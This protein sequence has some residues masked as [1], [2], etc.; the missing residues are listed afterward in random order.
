MLAAPRSS[1]PLKTSQ[2]AKSLTFFCRSLSDDSTARVTAETPT[3]SSEI[4][5]AFKDSRKITVPACPPFLAS[6]TYPISGSS[7]WHDA[8]LSKT[9]REP[10]VHLT[11]HE[12]QAEAGRGT[13]KGVGLCSAED[14]CIA[15]W[16]QTRQSMRRN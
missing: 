16:L 13:K 1:L 5:P 3:Y 10:G 4:Q 12:C 11:C 8:A 14:W 15:S 2:G 9:S 7:P 6:V